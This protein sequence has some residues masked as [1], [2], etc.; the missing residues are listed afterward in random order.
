VHYLGGFGY[1]VAEDTAIAERQSLEFL[2]ILHEHL[3]TPFAFVEHQTETQLITFCNLVGMEQC[4]KVL[5]FLGF[6]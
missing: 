2:L 1:A 5:A 6:L 4:D 3:Q